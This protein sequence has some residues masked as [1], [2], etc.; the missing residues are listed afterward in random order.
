MRGMDQQRL[1]LACSTPFVVPATSKRGYCSLACQP[2]HNK[3]TKSR[4]LVDVECANCGDVF[5]RK[6]WE[7]ELRERKGWAQYCSTSCRDAVKRGRKGSQRVERVPFVCPQ[8]G[9]TSF[10]APHELRR[11]KFCS[12][13]CAA[14]SASGRP[15][16]RLGNAYMSTEGYRFVYLAPEDRPKGHE[17]TSYQPEHRVVMAAILGRWPESFE[18]VHHINGDKADNRPE[19]LQLRIGSHGYGIALRCRCCGSSDIETVEL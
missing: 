7:V 3:S 10:H 9:E 4:P 18:S 6:A 13:S 17:A 16:P 12:S 19:N 2:R 11:R 8:C 1:C 15:R 14:K 5:Q